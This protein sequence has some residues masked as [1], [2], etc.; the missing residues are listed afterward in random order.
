MSTLLRGYHSLPCGEYVV[1]SACI[2]VKSCTLFR[3]LETA[4]MHTVLLT[5]RGP[6]HPAS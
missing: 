4:I 2:V 3:L 1:G 5:A 6:V